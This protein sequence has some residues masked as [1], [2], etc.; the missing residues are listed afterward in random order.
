LSY[1]LSHSHLFFTVGYPP[2]HALLPYTTL[3]RSSL[4]PGGQRL[5][6]DPGS[7]DAQDRLFA[8]EDDDTLVPLGADG[9]PTGMPGDPRLRRDRDRKS[10]RLNSSHVKIS[11]AVFCLKKKNACISC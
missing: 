10:T 1:V 4:E 11:Y 5:R 9:E 8:I 7:K 6:L 2:I 3:F